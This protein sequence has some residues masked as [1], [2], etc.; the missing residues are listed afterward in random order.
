V[1]VD[2]I[3]SSYH[4]VTANAGGY[5]V[6]VPGN[7][8]FTVTFTAPGLATH[9]QQVSVSSLINVK[10][11]Y[12]PVYSPP[13]VSGPNPAGINQ[14]IFTPSLRL[15]PQRAINGNKQESPRSRR[16]KALKTG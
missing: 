13:I 8:N 10:V 1:T 6:P 14:T 11:D 7:G 9:Q 15:V 3:G 5:A 4:G 16:S 12:L 2:V